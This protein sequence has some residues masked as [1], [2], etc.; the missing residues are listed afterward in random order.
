VCPASR[1]NR[2]GPRDDAAAPLRRRGSGKR[3]PFQPW[4]AGAPPRGPPRE[5]ARG[6]RSTGRTCCAAGAGTMY[7]VRWVS[8]SYGGGHRGGAGPINAAAP[9]R[10]GTRGQLRA[11]RARRRGPH[12]ERGRRR[13]RPRPTQPDAY[14]PLRRRECRAG[15]A[16]GAAAGAW[17]PRQCHP[18]RAPRQRATFPTAS[19]PPSHARASQLP[20]WRRARVR[21]AQAAR[22]AV[23]RPGKGRGVTT[24]RAG[25]RWHAGIAGAAGCRRAAGFVNGRG[26]GRGWYRGVR[27]G[28]VKSSVLRPG[29]GRGGLGR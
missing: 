25:R 23:A 11:L 13:A 28:S 19:L 12:H 18:A 2:F 6:A 8:R 1:Q 20:G 21:S 15:V 7:L 26:P 16:G 3:D 29:G 10:V 9:A 5:P 4:K 22:R 27:P 24:R 14:T 17:G